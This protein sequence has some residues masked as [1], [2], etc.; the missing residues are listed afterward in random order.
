MA[1]QSDGHQEKKKG[2]STQAQVKFIS[3]DTES[4]H[5]RSQLIVYHAREYGLLLLHVQRLS[6]MSC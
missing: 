6:F 4:F 2:S 3:F 1:G 5:L